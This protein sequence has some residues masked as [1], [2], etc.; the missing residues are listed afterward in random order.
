[1]GLQASESKK[2]DQFLSQTIHK[3]GCIRYFH[4][5][6]TFR[7]VQGRK[8]CILGL[9]W[10]R[11]PYNKTQQG[12]IGP[13]AGSQIWLIRVESWEVMGRAKGRIPLPNPMIFWKN[14]KRP[15]T[16]SK[17]FFDFSDTIFPICIYRACVRSLLCTK[18]PDDD[19]MTIL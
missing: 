4:V 2:G 10:P 12:Y 17:R 8:S 14:F 18:S 5:N 15:L 11:S 3:K 13:R 16:V 9:I 6:I 7:R 1:M 19:M